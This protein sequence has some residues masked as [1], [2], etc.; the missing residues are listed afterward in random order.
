MSSSKVEAR[1]RVERGIY[2]R[3]LADGAVRFEVV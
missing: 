1:Q 2:R 3:T